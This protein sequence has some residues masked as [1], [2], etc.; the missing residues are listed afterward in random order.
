MEAGGSNALPY[1]T[2]TSTGQESQA[3]KG[4]S[5]LEEPDNLEELAA[6][7]SGTGGMTGKMRVPAS[8]ALLVK[9]WEKIK[10][11]DMSQERD[12][13]YGDWSSVSRG[14]Q[15]GCFC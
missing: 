2:R 10:T 8:G 6:E 12:H 15:C 7:G 9:S 4:T 5:K 14:H 3:G 11:Q 13:S 1:S